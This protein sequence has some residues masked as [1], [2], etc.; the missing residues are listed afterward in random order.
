[1]EKLYYTPPKN[2]YFEE[3]KSK[4]MELWNTYDDEFGYASGK[5]NRIKDIENI[6]D[7]FMYIVAGFDYS[8]Q[9]KLFEKLSEET[10]KEVRKRM[11]DGGNNLE[12]IAF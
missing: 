4:A 11:I 1:M 5:I 12:D 2:K 9:R 3:L 7:N 10:R 8:N 6:K